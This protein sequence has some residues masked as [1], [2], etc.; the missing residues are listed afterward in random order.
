M[1]RKDKRRLPLA[2]IPNGSGN[3]TCG[4]LSVTDLDTALKY[5]VRGNVIKSDL[6]KVLLDFES[7]D[8]IE[9]AI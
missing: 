1:R 2:F 4:E 3:S 7:E 8:D 9:E 6:C 5:I